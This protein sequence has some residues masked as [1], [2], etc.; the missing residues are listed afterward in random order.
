M[1]N[2]PLNGID[3]L[4]A[5]ARKYLAYHFIPAVKQ[6]GRL[7][8]RE[9]WYYELTDA[10]SE[11]IKARI[12][13][14]FDGDG[15]ANNRFYDMGNDRTIDSEGKEPIDVAGLY[16]GIPAFGEYDAIAGLDR[17]VPMDT[18]KS[19]GFPTAAGFPPDGKQ[20]TFLPGPKQSLRKPHRLNDTRSPRL[21]TNPPTPT[22]KS[23]RSAGGR[24]A[25]T[26]RK[27]R[28]RD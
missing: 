24:S 23:C 5:A 8:L 28:G 14:I 13:L 26:G 22:A 17:E 19:Q 10:T 12:H 6:P 27:E 4:D 1:L 2:R 21:P 18:D 9:T 11:T 3:F 7:F 16:E 25:T 20:V 15:N